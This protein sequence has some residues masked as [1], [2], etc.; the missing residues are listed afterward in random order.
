MNVSFAFVF[1]AAVLV[2]GHEHI[3][4]PT[5]DPSVGELVAAHK[6]YLTT[7]LCPLNQRYR[8]DFVQYVIAKFGLH[9]SAETRRHTADVWM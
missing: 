6:P 8:Q 7:L 1:L 9:A 3:A 4:E 5:Q 2:N